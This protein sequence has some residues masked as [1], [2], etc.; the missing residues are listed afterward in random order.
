MF[1][2][3]IILRSELTRELPTR[4]HSFL[5]GPHPPP[6]FSPHGNHIENCQT[7]PYW[8]SHN[9]LC[10]FGM[11]LWPMKM[12]KSFC[13]TVKPWGQII[14]MMVTTAPWASRAHTKVPT[15]QLKTISGR[16]HDVIMEAKIQMIG[17]L[18]TSN[19]IDWASTQSCKA[20]FWTIGI[21]WWTKQSQRSHGLAF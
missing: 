13:L 20:L 3:L 12:S 15:S 21:H 16:F 18:V 10:I 14:H 7:S 9:L 17:L 2:V 11:R 6:H 19:N 8:V 4:T 5:W 1:Y